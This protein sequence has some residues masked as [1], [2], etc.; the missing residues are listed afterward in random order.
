MEQ[1][2]YTFTGVAGSNG[3][4][5]VYGRPS[6]TTEYGSP[7]TYYAAPGETKTI[8]ADY[9]GISA[10]MLTFRSYDFYV[11]TW[12]GS[13]HKESSVVS[14]TTYD[15]AAPQPSLVRRGTISIKTKWQ[16]F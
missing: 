6:G 11:K 14:A 13:K 12:S 5:H 15:I 7:I 8:T 2:T 4:Y 9:Y 1:V 10:P 3:A 16:P